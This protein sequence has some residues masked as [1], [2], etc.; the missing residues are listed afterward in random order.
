MINLVIVSLLKGLKF[1]T[2]TLT[3]RLETKTMHL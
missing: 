3:T 1:K 2:T